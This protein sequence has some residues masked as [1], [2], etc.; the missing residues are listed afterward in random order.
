MRN[1][2]SMRPLLRVA[3]LLAASIAGPAHAG[4]LP[5]VQNVMQLEP[6]GYVA[7]N[8]ITTPLL[9]P[10][11]TGKP[12]NT[13]FL[14]SIGRENLPPDLRKLQPDL[15]DI[16][17]FRVH[18]LLQQFEPYLNGRMEA[19]RNAKGYLVPLQ[20]KLGEYDFQRRRFPLSL[21]MMV[22]KPKSPDSYHCAGAYDEFRNTRLSACVSATNWNNQNK[23]FQFLAIDDMQQA[24]HIKRQLLNK[25]AGFYFLMQNDGRFRVV[26]NAKMKYG[27]FME[28]T[29]ASGVLPARVIGLLLVDHT[30]SAI[31]LAG[32]MTP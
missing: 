1:N 2:N 12:Y 30:N 15:E 3:A 17:E 31:I 8:K 4:A 14:L 26:D 19:L 25:Q 10:V 7:L 5:D 32:E 22:T 28:P 9:Y 13:K 23:A 21:D 18:A 6:E 24:E 20:A 29:L 27:G 11:H 16:N